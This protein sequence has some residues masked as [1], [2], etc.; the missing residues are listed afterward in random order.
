MIDPSDI[1]IIAA[2]VGGVAVGWGAWFAV[3]RGL[4]TKRTL[5]AAR[6]LVDA[7]LAELEHR[8]DLALERS[9]P[10][11]DHGEQLADAAAELRTNIEGLRTMISAVPTERK[12]MW[13]RFADV[14]L[15]TQDTEDDDD[16]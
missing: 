4:A 7:H 2:I 6:A 13:R 16:R 12:R 1:T 10:L 8:T 15:P 14:V 5:D 9:A 11:A 3:T